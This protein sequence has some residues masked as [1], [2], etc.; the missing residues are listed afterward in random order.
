MKIEC[1]KYYIL[2]INEFYKTFIQLFS[3]KTFRGKIKYTKLMN[4]TN[5][6]D[7]NVQDFKMYLSQYPFG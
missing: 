1:E 6:L 2:I 3:R 4:G 5:F 7:N